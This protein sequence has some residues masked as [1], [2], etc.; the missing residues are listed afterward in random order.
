MDKVLFTDITFEV[1]DFVAVINQ[2]LDYSY[3]NVS[4][5][6]EL[7]N[8]RISKNKWIY[9]DLKDNSATVHFFGTVY[10]LN[11]P[12]ENGMLLR[13]RGVPKLHPQYGF[14]VTVLQ[15]QPE[16]EG[17]LRR[18]ADLLRAKLQAEGLFEEDRKRVLPY[19]PKQL[20]LI[21]SSES[22]AFIDFIK[23]LNA[24]WRGVTIDCID[25]QVQGE[26]S[27]EQITAAISYFNQKSILPDVLILTRGGGSSED[28][29]AFDTEKVTRAVATSR[30]PTLVAIGHEKDISLAELAA[31]KRASTPSNAAELLVPDRREVLRQLEDAQTYIREALI[32]SIHNHKRTLVNYR[33]ELEHLMAS[34]LARLQDQLL[35]YT[36]LLEALNPRTILGRGYAIVRLASKVVIRSKEEVSSGDIVNIE[37]NDGRVDAI[38]R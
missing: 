7:A 17:A 10:Q 16:G 3:P 18:A 11:G 1:S 6:G 27:P 2:T 9:F 34:V 33:N 19:L 13:V 29:Y 24:R 8:F 22:A 5:K 25:V 35:A 38:I 14:S 36:N 32:T 20:G 15:L 30:V 4:I 23:V 37:L 12:L 21:T 26:A 28:L 31:D